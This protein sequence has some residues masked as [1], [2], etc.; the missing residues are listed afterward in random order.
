MLVKDTPGTKQQSETRGHIFVLDVLYIG[1]ED[2]NL[3][4][5]IWNRRNAM[6]LIA[7]A[8]SHGFIMSASD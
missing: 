3:H 7:F 1:Q 5:F 4:G 8:L 2:E 6:G